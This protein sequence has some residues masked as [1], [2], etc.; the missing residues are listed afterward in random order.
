MPVIFRIR[1]DLD[2]LWDKENKTLPVEITSRGARR[3]DHREDRLDDRRA[4]GRKVELSSEVD[5]EIIGGIIIRVGNRS[6]TPPFALAWSSCAGRCN[7]LRN[8][9]TRR[10][11]A[12]K[13]TMQIKPDEITSILQEPNRGTRQR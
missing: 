12:T 5:P 4:A 9:T 2:E 3:A 8:P 13:D 10:P 1:Q 7:S 6:S 11:G